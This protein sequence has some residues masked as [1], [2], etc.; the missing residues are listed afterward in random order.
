M[1]KIRHAA[2]NITE[3]IPARA[4]LKVRRKTLGWDDTDLEAALQNP[5]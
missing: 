2:R 3:A 5:S 4:S 1:A